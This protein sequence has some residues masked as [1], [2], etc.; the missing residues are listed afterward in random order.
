LLATNK[1]L[2]DRVYVFVNDKN[3]ALAA[4]EVVK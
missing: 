4:S 1:C 3:V 2:S